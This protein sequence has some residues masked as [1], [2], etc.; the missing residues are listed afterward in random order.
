MNQIPQLYIGNSRCHYSITSREIIHDSGPM[1]DE[2][3]SCKG[4]SL[5]QTRAY[6]KEHRLE[7]IKAISAHEALKKSAPVVQINNLVIKTIENKID[8]IILGR[9]RD[10]G[11]KWFMPEL[12][13]QYC[14]TYNIV[15]ELTW[16]HKVLPNG[17]IMKNAN[18]DGGIWVLKKNTYK[19]PEDTYDVEW[20]YSF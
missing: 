6:E 10:V 8:R 16:Y 9:D 3:C 12:P 7:I 2:T 13:R 14:E 19:N 17:K 5:E 20:M 15:K 18:H 1:S 4:N 11:V